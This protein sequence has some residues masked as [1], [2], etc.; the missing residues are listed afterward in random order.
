[1]IAP[2][3]ACWRSKCLWLALWSLGRID[4]LRLLQPLTMCLALQWS[5]EVDTWA[6]QLA[7]PQEYQNRGCNFYE[8]HRNCC[9]WQPLYFEILNISFV[10][11]GCKKMWKWET[12]WG[13]KHNYPRNILS[14]SSKENFILPVQLPNL[15]IR[16]HTI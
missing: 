13:V 7:K 11:F 10:T 12:L 14:V 5:N 3:T 9:F 16:C 15:R 1:M 8:T 2:H 6:A 4:R